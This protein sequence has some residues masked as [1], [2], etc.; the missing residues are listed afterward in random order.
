M[1]TTN[2]DRLGQPRC[3][4]KTPY[5]AATAPCGQK[6]RQQREVEPVL[7]REGAQAEHRVAGDRQHDRVVGLEVG[8]SLSRSS[9]SS[10]VQTRLNANG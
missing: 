4:S 3:S 6:S 5:A 1:S 10:P 8:D 2:V 7:L 9:A